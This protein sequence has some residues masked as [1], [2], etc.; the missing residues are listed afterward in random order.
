MARK[1]RS[2]TKLA[3]AKSAAVPPACTP[4][5]PGTAGPA[6]PEI[7]VVDDDFMVRRF[8]CAALEREGYRVLEAINGDEAVI[9]LEKAAPRLLITDLTMPQ[10]DGFGVIVEAVL[11]Y[12]DMKICAISGGLS[13]QS[14]CTPL[15]SALVLGAHCLLAKPFER[16][17]LVQ[18][19]RA[20]LPDAA[21]APGGDGQD[22][23]VAPKAAKQA[24]LCRTSIDSKP[25]LPSRLS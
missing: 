7:L 13:P 16:E 24:F 2:K 22:R 1:P 21:L 25:A 8:I 5:G 4:A 12:P 3:S 14:G 19:V 6:V 9:A 20:L 11:K 15:S 17:E 18:A 23:L 10:R